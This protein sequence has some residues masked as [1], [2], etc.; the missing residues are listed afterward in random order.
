MVPVKGRPGRLDL[1]D[2]R[3]R[4]GCR[5]AG[6]TLRHQQAPRLRRAARSAGRLTSRSWKPMTEV[7]R[8]HRDGVVACGRRASPSRRASSTQKLLVGG[9]A[10]AV[11]IGGCHASGRRAADR[12]D[13][14]PRTTTPRSA[15]RRTRTRRRRESHATPETQR[16]RARANA[17]GTRA[18]LGVSVVCGGS[19]PRSRPAARPSRPTGGRRSR[20]RST[21]GLLGRAGAEV[22]P[23]RRG[24][25]GQLGLGRGRPRRSRA[26]RS[27]CVRRRAHRA[28]VAG[29]TSGRR[30]ATS[31]SG[32]SNFG[33]WVSTASTVR[34]S[35]PSGVDDSACR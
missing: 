4:S 1:A 31:S 29:T 23:D 14:E 2:C 15:A 12:G 33:S 32:T 5:G 17:P 28:D 3:R 10:G 34:R 6:R 25:P 18:A 21:R 8:A 13:G 11:P 16:A 27:S 20:P 22:E 35:M 19:G 26:S 7:R 30:S 24:Q 9:G